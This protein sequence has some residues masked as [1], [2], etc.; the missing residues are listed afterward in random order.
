MHLSNPSFSPQEVTA[1][2]TEL[3]AGGEPGTCKCE[4]RGPAAQEE[5]SSEARERSLLYG[6]H[7]FHGFHP[8][9][10]GSC[11]AQILRRRPPKA[12]RGT[13]FNAKVTGPSVLQAMWEKSS[14]NLGR[15]GY[16]L[17]AESGY[18]PAE[19]SPFSGLSKTGTGDLNWD[20]GVQAA[21][22]ATSSPPNTTTTT[23][24]R[25]GMM[26]LSQSVQTTNHGVKHCH[27]SHSTDGE[28]EAWE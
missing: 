21:Q 19:G 10:L 13:C 20:L 16:H 14:A 22:G 9:C 17:A 26:P 8:C 28:S 1:G 5:W 25:E 24:S 6:F 4:D 3:A 23:T 11:P 12:A 27:R 15:C 18:L 2:I 7:G